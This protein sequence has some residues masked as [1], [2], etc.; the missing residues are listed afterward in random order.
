MPAAVEQV[1]EK[2]RAGLI[3]D[4]TL[5]SW[6]IQGHMDLQTYYWNECGEGGLGSMS[7]HDSRELWTL[8]SPLVQNP[9]WA[10]QWLLSA[11]DRMLKHMSGSAASDSKV[12]AIASH[13]AH[14]GSGCSSPLARWLRRTWR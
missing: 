1:L 5:L 14:S 4:A 12:P 8:L 6:L 13:L 11:R 9:R 3:S 7:P 10:P 2:K